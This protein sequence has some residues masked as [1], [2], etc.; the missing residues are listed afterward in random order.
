M[1]NLLTSVLVFFSFLLFA[2]KPTINTAQRGNYFQSKVD[3]S[4]KSVLKPNTKAVRKIKDKSIFHKKGDAFFI[5]PQ[6][7]T[8]S[9][10][11]TLNSYAPCKEICI[12]FS[13]GISLL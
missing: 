7:N 6:I 10:L 2:Q 3:T 1:K 9:N 12:G 5:E 4:K 11:R 8:S 13:K